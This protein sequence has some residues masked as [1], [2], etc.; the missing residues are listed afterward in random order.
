MTLVTPTFTMLAVSLA[1]LFVAPVALATQAA[2]AVAPNPVRG[3]QLF[4]QCRACHSVAPGAPN[5]IGPNLTGVVGARAATRPGYSY[6]PALAKSGLVWTSATL[7]GF[8]K[9]PSQ[10]VPGTKMSF[11][12]V[13]DATTRA[14]IIAYLT[15]LKAPK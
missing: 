11:A 5:A 15:T 3:G 12:G 8:L 1:G 6:S 13:A 10:A 4:L 7:D 9:R 2:P 14:D